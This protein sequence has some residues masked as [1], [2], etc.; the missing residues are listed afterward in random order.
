M[1]IHRISPSLTLREVARLIGGEPLGRDGVLAPGPGHGPQDCSLRVWLDPEAPDGFRVY[2]FAGDDPVLCRHHVRERLGLPPP[3][4]SP[5][6]YCG[7]Q[8]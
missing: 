2:S 5:L 3:P 4:L 7:G 8:A 6:G 1:Q